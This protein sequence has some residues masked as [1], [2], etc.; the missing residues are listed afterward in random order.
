MT[1]HRRT[2]PPVLDSAHSDDGALRG[3]AAI[4]LDYITTEAALAAWSDARS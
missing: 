1:F 4:G 2:P 3:A